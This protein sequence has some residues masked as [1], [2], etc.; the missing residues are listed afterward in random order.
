MRRTGVCRA[1][2]ADV[3]C[4]A[5][6]GV[7]HCARG[8]LLLRAG[9][10]IFAARGGVSL[11]RGGVIFAARK[12]AVFVARDGGVRAGRGS[13][14]P[15]RGL[16]SPS[17]KTAHEKAPAALPGATLHGRALHGRALHG[18]ALPRRS[19]FRHDASQC[20]PSRRG[21]RHGATL[22][23]KPHVFM[24][25]VFLCDQCRAARAILSIIRSS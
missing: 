25:S 1:E 12:R 5:P 7:F 22:F 21:K 6:G 14:Q 17:E 18:R 16:R 8:V 9:R 4:C 23:T 3:F 13:R 24:L 19:S 10:A 15:L 20:N 2:E 11:R